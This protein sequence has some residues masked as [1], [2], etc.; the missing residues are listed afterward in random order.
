MR[1]ELS[2]GIR[3]TQKEYRRLVHKFYKVHPPFGTGD[4]KR[5]L[6]EYRQL[7]V[8]GLAAE[9]VVLF[10]LSKTQNL[11]TLDDGDKC[12]LDTW[13]VEFPKSNLKVLAG[14][15]LQPY[16]RAF[17]LLDK[18]WLHFRDEHGLPDGARVY[19]EYLSKKMALA[20]NPTAPPPSG[21]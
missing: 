2:D 15:S 6:L 10:S 7:I 18:N 14:S 4:M 5:D 8:R 1:S 13:G 12:L 19:F 17:D 11:S 21:V 3:D 20:L 9:D 16:R